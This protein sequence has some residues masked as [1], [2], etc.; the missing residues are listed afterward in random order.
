MN[1]GSDS[2]LSLQVIEAVA[3]VKDVDPLELSP[4]LFHAINP[5]ALDRIFQRDGVTV[6]FVWQGCAIEIDQNGTIDVRP[7][8]QA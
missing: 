4:P 7:T 8:E 5:E 1:D 2:G 6:S 3:D